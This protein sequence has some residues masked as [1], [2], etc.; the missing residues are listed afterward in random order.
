MLVVVPPPAP[1]PNA[2]AHPPLHTRPAHGY[3]EHRERERDG[4]SGNVDDVTERVVR[5]RLLECLRL[6]SE[7][8]EHQTSGRLRLGSC[9]ARGNSVNSPSPPRQ[10]Y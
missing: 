7:R 6:L 5:R 1:A 4:N 9:A 2:V 3:E 10:G 8:D